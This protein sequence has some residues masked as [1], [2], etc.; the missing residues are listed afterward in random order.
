MKQR[1]D[2]ITSTQ[3]SLTVIEAVTKEKNET[4]NFNDAQAG[5]M[6]KSKPYANQLRKRDTK[7]MNAGELQL[8]E[9]FTKRK[10][11]G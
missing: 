2:T 5:Q 9:R 7:K 4:Q 1:S 8:R 3:K 10:K 6:C 11:I